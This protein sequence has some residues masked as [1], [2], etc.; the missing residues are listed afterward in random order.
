MLHKLKLKCDLSFSLLDCFIFNS[1]HILSF[2]FA[3][4]KKEEIVNEFFTVHCSVYLYKST[5]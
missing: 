4:I 2:F 3:K 1:I 5:S